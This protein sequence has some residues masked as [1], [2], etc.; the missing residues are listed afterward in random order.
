MVKKNLIN[1]FECG[2]KEVMDFNADLIKRS[3]LEQ[4][5]KLVKSTTTFSDE[6]PP[7]KYTLTVTGIHIGTPKNYNNIAA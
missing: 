6:L 5:F 3:L 4:G 2:N 7:H 1:V